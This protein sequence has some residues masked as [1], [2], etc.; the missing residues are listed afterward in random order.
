MHDGAFT[1]GCRKRHPEN[2]S[3]PGGAEACASHKPLKIKGIEKVG[4]RLCA[5][6]YEYCSVSHKALHRISWKTES[7]PESCFGFHYR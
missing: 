4:K 7:M 5:E 6:G 3:L 1:G 2:R